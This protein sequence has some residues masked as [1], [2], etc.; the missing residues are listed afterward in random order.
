MKLRC[1][2][3]HRPMVGTTAYDGACACGGLIEVDPKSRAHADGQK[4]GRA[5][6]LIGGEPNDYS[7]HGALDPRSSYSYSY[8]LGYRAGWTGVR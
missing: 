4:A 1:N 8:N 3:C 5:D 6:R 7:W 2:R